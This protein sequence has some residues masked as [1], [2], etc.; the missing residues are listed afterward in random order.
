MATPASAEA[1]LYDIGQKVFLIDD[2]AR[3]TFDAECFSD[4]V[5]RVLLAVALAAPGGYAAT[6]SGLA[7]VLQA[8]Y[9]VVLR[10][11]LLLE[12]KGYLNRSSLT[13]SNASEDFCPTQDG[14]E[15]LEKFLNRLRLA[16]I[17]HEG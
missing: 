4:G 13:G 2:Y 14:M 8:S 10:K 1:A 15:L 9:S 7:D 6:P 5:W 12:R 16:G 11:A 17:F 3:Q